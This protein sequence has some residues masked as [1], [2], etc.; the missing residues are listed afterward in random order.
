MKLLLSIVVLFFITA[1]GNLRPVGDEKIEQLTGVRTMLG[2][3]FCWTGSGCLESSIV[4]AKE[5]CTKENKNYSY[6]SHEIGMATKLQY[7]C[8]PILK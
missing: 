8:I 1:C 4:A 2:N 3:T 5:E 6:V 7:K